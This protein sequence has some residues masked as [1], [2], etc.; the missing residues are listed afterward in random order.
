MVLDVAQTDAAAVDDEVLVAERCPHLELVDDD[1]LEDVRSDLVARQQQRA[2][3][4]ANED[5]DAVGERQVRVL[6]VEAGL[7][8]ADDPNACFPRALG[9]TKGLEVEGPHHVREQAAAERR[10]RPRV[11]HA[12]EVTA[13]QHLA[14]PLEVVH[15]LAADAQE[16]G[17]ERR[18]L[19][20]EPDPLRGLGR[21]QPAA[22]AVAEGVLQPREAA[23]RDLGL[24]RPQDTQLARGLDL[25]VARQPTGRAHRHPQALQA[26]LRRH[27]LG[28]K[29]PND[30][31]LRL[32]CGLRGR[33]LRQQRPEQGR[34]RDQD[35]RG[36]TVHARPRIATAARPT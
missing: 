25:E 10:A 5:L 19:F 1:L 8:A 24:W 23:R 34:T 6:L 9:A 12:G 35:A 21:L 17:A 18:V 33:L 29:P 30:S 2:V 36:G 14:R 3:S 16:H 26:L 22:H 32:V 11:H 20:E 4:I 15:D 13:V 27:H 31:V 7:A 28:H